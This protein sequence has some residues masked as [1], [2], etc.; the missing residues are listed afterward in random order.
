VTPALTV[1]KRTPVN[2]TANATDADGD[3][4]AFSWI[5]IAGPGV[6]I[7][8]TQTPNLT[9]VPTVSGHYGFEVTVSDGFVESTSDI[10]NITVIN[11]D[12]V[13][14]LTVPRTSATVGEQVVFNASGS[15]D[16]DDSIISYDFH[17]GDGSESGWGPSP[18]AVHTYGATGNYTSNVSVRDE[19]GRENTSAPVVI[20]VAPPPVPIPKLAL[21]VPKEGDK[22]N[23]TTLQVM[24]TVENFTV[25]TTG[26]HIHYQLDNLTEVMWFSLSPFTLVNLTDGMHLLKVYLADAN[27]T[28]LP[29]PEAFV[30]VNFTVQLPPMADLAVLAADLKL[31]PSSPKDGDTVT[32]SA[33]VHNI[34]DLDAGAFAV[35][36]FVD[37]T[38]L[39]DQNVVLLAKG[40]STVVQAKWK[41]TSGSH[42]I[43]VR[44]N[45]GGSLQESSTANNE[46]SKTVNVEKKAAAAEFPWLLVTAVVIVLV[47]VLLLAAVMMTRKK[48]T[49]VIPYQPPPAQAPVAVQAPPPA[50]P[51]A[52]VPQGPPSPPPTSPPPQVPPPVPPPQ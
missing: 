6:A 20:T 33:T 38:A 17:F 44:L 9:F 4:L 43:V 46:V 51:P 45:P 22:T 11:A 28:R 21:T 34:G 24:F 41:A 49:V 1:N 8:G 2:I 35:R 7:N 18:V 27:H 32:I 50:S 5:Q 19:E 40:G 30:Q 15:S 26:G 12:P 3:P 13:A 10:V 23:A 25:S 42:A 31:G 39:P 14:I 52:Q 48:P 16:V 47:V 36:F 29:N 37:G